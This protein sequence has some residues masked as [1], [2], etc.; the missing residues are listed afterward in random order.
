MRHAAVLSDRLRLRWNRYDTD[1][2]WLDP[3]AFSAG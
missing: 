2:A 3:D 1:D